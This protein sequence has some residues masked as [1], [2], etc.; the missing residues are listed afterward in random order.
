[1]SSKSKTKH[2]QLVKANAETPDQFRQE[3]QAAF[4]KATK[5]GVPATLVATKLVDIANDLYDT[6]SGDDDAD[7]LSILGL[8]PDE[9]RDAA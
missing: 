8:N 6:N 5:S 1:M 2:P 3:I 9:L 7:M 4:D